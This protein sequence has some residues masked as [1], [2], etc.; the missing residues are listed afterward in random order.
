MT[1]RDFLDL[2]RGLLALAAHLPPAAIVERSQLNI[3][4]TDCLFLASDPLDLGLWRKFRTDCLD[5]L[6]TKGE[7]YDRPQ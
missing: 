6:Q 7:S 4:A 1:F 5:Y 3:L 2:R